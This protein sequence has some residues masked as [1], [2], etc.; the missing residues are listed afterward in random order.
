MVL[1]G[2]RVGAAHERQRRG[3]VTTLMFVH[4]RCETRTKPPSLELL[5]P[6]RSRSK[7]TKEYK[8]HHTQQWGEGGHLRRPSRVVHLWNARD[9][10]FSEK[11][12][13]HIIYCTDN[14]PLS[15]R[16]KK[17]PLYHPRCGESVGWK[18]DS[19]ESNGPGNNRENQGK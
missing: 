3:G 17:C 5:P 18:I 9:E 4:R 2:P 10:T 1:V 8:K 15:S 16:N 13:H 6:L 12:S 7:L 14:T 19:S 11:L